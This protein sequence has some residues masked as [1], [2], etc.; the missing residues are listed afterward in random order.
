[1]NQNQAE[2]ERPRGGGLTLFLAFVGGALAGGTAAM[3]LAPRSGADTRRRLAGAVDG[4]K[5]VAS[6]VPKAIHQASHAAQ[7][8]FAAALKKS[9]PD[10]KADSHPHHS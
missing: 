9:A 2:M 6:R 1:M 8:A 7:A 3:L 4:T 5:D 10:D